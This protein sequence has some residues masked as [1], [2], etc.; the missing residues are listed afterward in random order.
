MLHKIREWRWKGN[1]SGHS[2]DYSE[3]FITDDPNFASKIQALNDKWEKKDGNYYDDSF[4]IRSIS[5][6]IV[7]LTTGE[8]SLEG[9]ESLQ[10]YVFSNYNYSNNG[11]YFAIREL[12]EFV[13]YLNKIKR[14]KRG[15]K[16][17]QNLEGLYFDDLDFIMDNINSE[18]DDYFDF[19]LFLADGLFKVTDRIYDLVSIIT[20]SVICNELR[21]VAINNINDR[22]IL[23]SIKL[24]SEEDKLK[25][26]IIK[27][28]E[29]K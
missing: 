17:I 7:H 25:N 14:N 1:W 5:D 19:L 16:F 28:L 26:A 15:Q 11:N 24:P 18:K 9:F 20:N 22:E 3:I 6:W 29:L 21:E 10:E 4:Y 27:K 13:E 23:K 2:V 8:F 12:K